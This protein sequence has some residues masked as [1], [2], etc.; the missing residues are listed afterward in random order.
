MWSINDLMGGGKRHTYIKV[1]TRP[2]DELVC[3]SEG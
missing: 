2:V 3:E 1:S